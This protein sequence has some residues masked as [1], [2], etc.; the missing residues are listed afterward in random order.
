MPKLYANSTLCNLIMYF[1][2]V[3]MISYVVPLTQ[4]NGFMYFVYTMCSPKHNSLKTSAQKPENQ[5]K[6][7]FY[8][9]WSI[10]WRRLLIIFDRSDIHSI[11][12]N[13]K[14]R[15]PSSRISKMWSVCFKY[16]WDI[17]IFA[18]VRFFNASEKFNLNLK[19]ISLISC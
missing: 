14:K 3:Y 16:D 18:L 17:R 11:K 7:T 19:C 13:L 4:V 6:T 1:C 15:F 9:I 12:L 8:H 2:T 5:V 10:K